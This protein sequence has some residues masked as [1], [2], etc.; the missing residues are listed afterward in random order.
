MSRRRETVRVAIDGPA[1]VGKTTSAKALADR[2][3]F[4]YVDT[5][6]MYRA[7]ALK[8]LDRGIS[9]D[10]GRKTGELAGATDVGL[11]PD[12]KGGARVI[13]DGA[14]VTGRIRSPEVSDGASRIA[15]HA[16]VRERM[17]ALQRSIGLG[18]NVVMEGRDIGTR[19]LPEAEAKIYLTAT[20]EERA[21]RRWKEL[22]SRGEEARYDDVL[23]GIRERD[24]RD[25]GREI[26]PLRPADGATVIDCTLLTPEAQVDAI[27]D[28]VLGSSMRNAPGGAAE[29]T[30]P[31]LR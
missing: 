9:P 6:A 3:G 17:V 26:D 23:E 25:T 21:L 16:R 12:G 22:V 8:A 15:V 27:M 19:V 5:G 13:L 2:L 29:E 11:E 18:Q 31:E 4:L 7:L 14:D 10:D 28:V 24:A 20:P 1:G 30:G